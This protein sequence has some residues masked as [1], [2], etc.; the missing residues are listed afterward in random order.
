MVTTSI[1]KKYSGLEITIITTISN[2]ILNEISDKIYINTIDKNRYL[3]RELVWVK[4]DGLWWVL[5]DCKNDPYIKKDTAFY[6]ED[7]F[8]IHLIKSFEDPN[9]VQI[10]DNN[11]WETVDLKTKPI[12]KIISEYKSKHLIC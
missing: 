7:L 11:S 6:D 5:Q 2:D 12:S 10:Y 8:L 4:E 1:Y 9:K 3:D